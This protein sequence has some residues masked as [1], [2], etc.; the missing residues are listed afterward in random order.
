[1]GDLEE[2]LLLSSLKQSLSWFRFI[3]D[4]DMKGIRR[5]LNCSLFPYFSA[6]GNSII[7][8]NVRVKGSNYGEFLKDKN[9]LLC[10][11]LYKYA[12]KLESLL[13]M[14]KHATENSI[15]KFLTV[16]SVSRNHWWHYQHGCEN[17]RSQQAKNKIRFHIYRAPDNFQ[18]QRVITSYF[19]KWWVFAYFL[20][21]FLNL[22]FSFISSLYNFHGNLGLYPIKDKWI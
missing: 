14:N 17:C 12:P 10:T 5:F 6:C 22:I 2:R 3:D 15:L 21:T 18:V 1:M 20:C 7:M 11:R 4:V 9:V 8:G 16:S 19:W 13:N